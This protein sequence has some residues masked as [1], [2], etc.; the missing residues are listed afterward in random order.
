MGEG[1]IKLKS[2]NTFDLIS[3]RVS[4]AS[5]N[6]DIFPVVFFLVSRG[7]K[8]QKNPNIFVT[9]SHIIYEVLPFV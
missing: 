1:V 4:S 7:G 3:V 9:I 8:T 5:K 2:R 6:F